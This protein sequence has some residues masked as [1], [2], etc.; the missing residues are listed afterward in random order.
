MCVC[1]SKR[2]RSLQRPPLH[3]QRWKSSRLVGPREWTQWVVLHSPAT[4]TFRLAYWWRPCAP[5]SF[6]VGHS[7]RQWETTRANQI[8]GWS[9]GS[10]QFWVGRSIKWP[11]DDPIRPEKN[12]PLGL[13]GRGGKEKH[14]KVKDNLKS[15]SGRNRLLFE[16]VSSDLGLSFHFKLKRIQFFFI[17]RNLSKLLK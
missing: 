13:R 4:C 12:L 2:V 7:F 6:K 9:A 17:S 15:F 11:S 16:T 1:V 10:A 5:T 14:E 3:A 8:G